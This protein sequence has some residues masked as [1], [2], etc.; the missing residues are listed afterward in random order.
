MVLV[1][2]FLFLLQTRAA[3]EMARAAAEFPSRESSPPTSACAGAGMS[4]GNGWSEQPSSGQLPPRPEWLSGGGGG[5]G[6]GPFGTGGPKRRPV[7]A[8]L[9]LA[10]MEF[11]NAPGGGGGGAQF[12]PLS[13]SSASAADSASARSLSPFASIHER[14]LAPVVDPFQRSGVSPTFSDGSPRAAAEQPSSASHR[15][16][17]VPSR[18]RTWEQQQLDVRGDGRTSPVTA[19]VISPRAASGWAKAKESHGPT[20]ARSTPAQGFA[21]VVQTASAA[22]GKPNLMAKPLK[23]DKKS[24]RRRR[25]S[26]NTMRVTLKEDSFAASLTQ[27]A[28]GATRGVTTVIDWTKVDSRSLSHGGRIEDLRNNH[29][30]N[31]SYDDTR[32]HQGYV[33]FTVRLLCLLLLAVSLVVLLVLILAQFFQ[34]RTRAMRK[35]AAKDNNKVHALS[36]KQ[37]KKL[38]SQHSKGLGAM[39]PKEAAEEAMKIMVYKRILGAVNP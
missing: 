4:S 7:V 21:G 18:R 17:P 3:L 32:N 1:L 35:Q 26:V 34:S 20:R 2:T 24:G 37:R 36:E 25:G 30:L 31:T 5:G 22:A 23:G 8:R 16:V 10:G 19:T 11:L 39:S 9:Q 12:A 6:G 29:D 27:M 33:P 38:A 13:A 15:A 28:D 14:Q